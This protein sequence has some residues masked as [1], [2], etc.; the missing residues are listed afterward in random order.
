MACLSYLKYGRANQPLNKVVQQILYKDTLNF[1][2]RKIIQFEQSSARIFEQRRIELLY[3]ENYTLNTCTM[4][5]V[6]SSIEHLCKDNCTR[7]H[8]DNYIIDSNILFMNLSLFCLL[9]F[10]GAI[11][12][13]VFFNI[14]RT[15]KAPPPSIWMPKIFC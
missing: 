14:S 15:S 11:K 4:I 13:T 5:I 10:R 6:Q 12:K 7:Q 1:C 3:K 8:N 9:H 2:A